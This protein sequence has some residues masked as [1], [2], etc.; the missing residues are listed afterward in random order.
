M[1]IGSTIECLAILG[2]DAGKLPELQRQRE[3]LQ[4]AAAAAGEELAAARKPV[5]SLKASQAVNGC[6][7]SLAG[8]DAAVTEEV[9][10][11]VKSALD[12]SSEWV[13]KARAELLKM[14]ADVFDLL[15]AAGKL[16]D[17]RYKR[18]VELRTKLDALRSLGQD[19]GM[20]VSDVPPARAIPTPWLDSFPWANGEYKRV[21]L[22]RFTD[23]SA[24]GGVPNFDAFRHWR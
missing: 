2:V 20:P 14:D 11:L 23:C 19:A 1:E 22:Q 8:L 3:S 16:M 18:S 10:A 6:Q 7:V 4:A 9:S 21:Y 15:S 17:M 5:D 12:N 24:A 13:G